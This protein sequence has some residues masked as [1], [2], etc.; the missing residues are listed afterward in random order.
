MAFKHT[1]GPTGRMG[2]AARL[3]RCRVTPPA[4]HIF[5]STPILESGRLQL[6][7]DAP[8]IASIRTT[9]RGVVT[10]SSIAG[11]EHHVDGRDA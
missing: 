2:Q 5:V 6:H 3:G 1:C 9:I 7:E 4:E 10:A 11:S 8:R